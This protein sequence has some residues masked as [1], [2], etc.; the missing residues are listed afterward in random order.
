V[1]GPTTNQARLGLEQGED[2]RFLLEKYY[3]D[4]GEVQ[5]VV[6]VAEAMFTQKNLPLQ[7]SLSKL[8]PEDLAYIEETNRA[9]LDGPE[10]I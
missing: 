4:A 5:R 6:E 1:D 7:R 9:F 8:T 2:L 10:D 3:D